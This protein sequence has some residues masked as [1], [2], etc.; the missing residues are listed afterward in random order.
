MDSND[1]NR[2]ILAI[3]IFT[4]IFGALSI[5]AVTNLF[6]NT[7]GN[8]EEEIVKKDYIKML[9]EE[10][11]ITLSNENDFEDFSSIGYEMI[12]MP[13]KYDRYTKPCFDFVIEEDGV[14]ITNRLSK[15]FD[16]YGF[17]RGDKIIK[18]N[19]IQLQGKSY[20]E[21]IDLIYAKT[22]AE[23]KKF[24]L[25]DN[26]EINYVYVNTK[27]HIEYDSIEKVLYVYNLDNISIKIIHEYVMKEPNLTLDLSKATVNTEEGLIDFLSLFSDENE[28]ILDT[29]NGGVVGQKHR[30][31]NELNIKI[32]D[33]TDNGILFAMTVIK[34]INSN[35][36]IDKLELNTYSFQAVKKLVSSDYIINI[37]NYTLRC[38]SNLNS[39][40]GV[41]L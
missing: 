35:I 22:Y 36:K 14:I 40:G 30:K 29:E 9:E 24:T 4:I 41:I 8:K 7:T 10:F 31:I 39:N 3:V 19:D 25:S 38:P 5:F 20:F 15:E 34:T 6:K 16:D 13:E 27:T 21:I 12:V 1:K 26:R 2:K 11:G 33:N 32:A 17:V 18:I 37:K 23:N 28:V